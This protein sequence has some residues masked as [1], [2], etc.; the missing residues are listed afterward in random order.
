MT[1]PVL[2]LLALALAA[3]C[4][5]SSGA[6]APSNDCAKSAGISQPTGHL[7]GHQCSKSEECR[8][9]VCLS[10]A[11]QKAT[12][13]VSWGVCSK[14]CSCGPG[15][16]CS[17]DD[18]SGML[19]TCIKAQQGGG[20]ECAISCDSTAACEKINPDMRC[21]SSVEYSQWFQS[22]AKGICVPK[23]AK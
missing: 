16:A 4:E 23:S 19:F 8:Y 15:S 22:A 12:A 5:T 20:S 10:G 3:A 6:G 14:D 11:L 13:Y 18:D 7:H 17:L 21:A 9:G 2:A 1:R